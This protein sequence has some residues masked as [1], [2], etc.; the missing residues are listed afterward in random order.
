MS[1]VRIGVIGAGVIGRT[2]I[3]T[4]QQEPTCQIAGIADPTPAAAE[5]AQQQGIPHS[6]FRRP[7]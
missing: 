2:H 6:A 5:Y 1:T 3:Q 4:M 7:P